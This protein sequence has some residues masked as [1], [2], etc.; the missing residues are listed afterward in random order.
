[1][2][3]HRADDAAPRL[4]R[5][6]E[7]DPCCAAVHAALTRATRLCTAAEVVTDILTGD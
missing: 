6:I 2:T 3:E 4:P 7:A 5:A 1:M